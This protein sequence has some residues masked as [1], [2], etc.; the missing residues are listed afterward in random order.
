MMKHS[1]KFSK[2]KLRLHGENVSCA[3]EIVYGQ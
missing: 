1:I 3:L 2:D